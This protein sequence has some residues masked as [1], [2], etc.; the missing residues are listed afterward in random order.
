MAVG[1]PPVVS[2]TE[3]DAA[4]TAMAERETSVAAS[5]HQLAT[6]RKRMPMRVDPLFVRY[7]P[8]RNGRP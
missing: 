3:W 4:L 1:R 5:M 8:D 6:A 2:R 7:V